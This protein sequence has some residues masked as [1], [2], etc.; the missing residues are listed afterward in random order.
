MNRHP[1]LVTRK[2]IELSTHVKRQVQRE[3]CTRTTG[4]PN[5]ETVASKQ[6]VSADQRVA[7]DDRL[8]ALA[9][10]G[11]KGFDHLDLGPITLLGVR[12]PTIA[13]RRS[14]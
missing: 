4:E 8:P 11:E 10:I 5:D 9:R 1:S 7:R 6:N 3:A 12:P 13:D 14:P 2:S